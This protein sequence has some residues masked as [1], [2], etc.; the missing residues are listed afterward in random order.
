VL[1]HSADASKYRS[2][3]DAY[4]AIAHKNLVLLAAGKRPLRK[5]TVSEQ[6]ASEISQ[7]ARDE[8]F[9]AIANLEP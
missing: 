2:A 3:W 9:A 7:R 5:D 8:L 4:Q 6:K 1:D